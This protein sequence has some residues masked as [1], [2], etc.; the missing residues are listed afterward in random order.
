MGFETFALISLVYAVVGVGIVSRIVRQRRAIFDLKFTEEDRRHVTEAAFFILLPVSVALHEFGHAFA[1]WSFGGEVVDFGFYVFAGFVGHRGFYTDT[2]RILIALAGPAVNVVL[3]AAALAVVF[4][5]RPPLRPAFNE[6]LV[7]FAI[8]SA[9]NALVFY[10]LLDVSIGL[11]ADWSQIYSGGVLALSTAIGICHAGILGLGFWASRNPGLRR[12]LAALTG[13]PPGAERGLFGDIGRVAGGGSRAP[14]QQVNLSP[15]GKTLM[16]A[17]QR[18]ASG[19]Q[20]SVDASIHDR[21][22]ISALALTWQSNDR[23]RTVVARGLPTGATEIWGIV[24]RNGSEPASPVHRRQIKQWPSPPDI[25]SLTL[26]LRLAMEEVDTW[27][28]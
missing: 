24:E 16:E 19:W 13:L 28:K 6:L 12:R 15:A 26:N 10:P 20:T 14:A 7:Q 2:E 1:V 5:R 11:N 18:V 9:L 22:G 8:L 3:S 25:D 17:G 27:P 23:R 4:I 21:D